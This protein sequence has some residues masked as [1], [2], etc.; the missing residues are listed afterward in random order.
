[1]D[2]LSD[3]AVGF[4]AAGATYAAWGAVW[5]ILHGDDTTLLGEA[6]QRGLGAA[7]ESTVRSGAARETQLLAGRVMGLVG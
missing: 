1:M 3:H 4:A 7:A 5:A 6:Q 2:W